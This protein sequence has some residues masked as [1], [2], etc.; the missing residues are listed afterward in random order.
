M[1]T[2][3]FIS[4]FQLIWPVFYML[5]DMIILRHHIAGGI[6]FTGGEVLTAREIKAVS[7]GLGGGVKFT[8]ASGFSYDSV[9]LPRVT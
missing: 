2:S 7:W 4:A 8:P 6:M 5:K 9:G 1:H 3:F